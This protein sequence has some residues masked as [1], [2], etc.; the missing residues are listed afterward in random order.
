M[1]CPCKD[2][3]VVCVCVCVAYRYLADCTA[4]IVKGLWLNFKCAFI[5][6]RLLLHQLL[7][8]LLLLLLSLLLLQLVKLLLSCL[9]LSLF[10]RISD[11]R[12]RF[13]LISFQIAALAE[14]AARIWAIQMPVNCSICGIKPPSR[15][16]F[17]PAYCLA[18]FVIAAASLRFPFF[19]VFLSCVALLF[20]CPSLLF[21]TS[22]KH[23]SKHFRTA[24][25]CC[26]CA[27]GSV[28]QCEP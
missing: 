6:T 22:S 20:V 8:L 19:L 16:L 5:C 10:K 3:C 23:V 7:P 21:T 26:H 24:S 14:R 28:E 13:F 11:C 9:S 1:C 25:L 12:L 4:S 15:H 2:M 17:W 18:L 27:A